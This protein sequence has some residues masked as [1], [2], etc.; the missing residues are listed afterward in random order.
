MQTVDLEHVFDVAPTALWE[1]VWDPRLITFMCA[2][3]STLERREVLKEEVLP[4]GRTR[5]IV[6]S[7]PRDRVPGFARKVLSVEMLAWEEEQTFFRKLRPED[8][9]ISFTITPSSGLRSLFSCH[10]HYTVEPIDEGKRSRR[11]IHF[12]IEVR[13][14]P[15]VRG[16]AERYLAS[17][18]SRGLDEEAKEM[19]VFLKEHPPQGLS[20]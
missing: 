14:G 13:V 3:L 6:R 15:L 17:E 4:D 11:M 18:I 2:R 16:L 5:R 7:V 19:V 1:A 9:T 20:H 10:G 8:P 12:E